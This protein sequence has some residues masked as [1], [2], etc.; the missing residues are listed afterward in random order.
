MIFDKN[1]FILQWTE[2]A[3][4]DKLVIEKMT[5]PEIIVPAAE[6]FSI[7]CHSWCV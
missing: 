3:K 6:L 5:V 7:F 1:K 4:E 2:K